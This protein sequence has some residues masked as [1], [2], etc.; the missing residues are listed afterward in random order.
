MKT[1]LI[2]KIGDVLKKVGK[3]VRC[4]GALGDPFQFTIVLEFSRRDIKNPHKFLFL[5]PRLKTPP[6]GPRLHMLQRGLDDAI[7]NDLVGDLFRG[8]GDDLREGGMVM[9]HEGEFLRGAAITHDRD[10]FVD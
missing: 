8:I 9:G 5:W 2:F 4:E 6:A 10:Q 1:D 3:R 7:G